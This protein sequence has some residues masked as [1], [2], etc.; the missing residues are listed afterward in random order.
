M[1]HLWKVDTGHRY[2]TR[3][4]LRPAKHARRHK[5]TGITTRYPLAGIAFLNGGD[6]LTWLVC[7]S[8][9]G[10]GVFKIDLNKP[11]KWKE[12]STFGM[13]GLPQS[14]AAPTQGD[15]PYVVLGYHGG[16]AAIWDV[17]RQ[18]VVAELTPWLAQHGK[19]AELAQRNSLCVV[20]MTPKGDRVAVGSPEDDYI[21][22]W[23][24]DGDPD[25]PDDNGCVPWRLVGQLPP[26]A[27]RRVDS[28]A[29]SLDGSLLAVGGGFK[30]GQ[31]E[32][33]DL[34]KSHCITFPAHDDAVW[35]LAFAR[36][37]KDPESTLLVS[38]SFDRTT[39]VWDLKTI[40][41]LVERSSVPWRDVPGYGGQNFSVLDLAALPRPLFHWA[42]SDTLLA[43]AVSPGSTHLATA[44]ADY[45]VSLWDFERLLEERGKSQNLRKP[46]GE[47]FHA[48]WIHPSGK[49]FAVA[50][51]NGE[52]R[53]SGE[54]GKNGGFEFNAGGDHPMRT[55]QFSRD[56]QFLAYG[57]TAGAGVHYLKAGGR[58]PI[59]TAGEKIFAVA[60]SH[61]ERKPMLALG[62]DDG[63]VL[64]AE[65]LSQKPKLIGKLHEGCV[66][67]LAFSPD[68]RWMASVGDDRILILTDLSAEDGFKH[69]EFG[70]VAGH[71]GRIK[72]IV[73]SPCG[74]FIATGGF[75]N[76]KLWKWIPGS[77]N[78]ILDATLRGHRDEIWTLAFSQS[79]RLL[80]SGSHDCTA[81]VWGRGE[82]CPTLLPAM[83]QQ[84]AFGVVERE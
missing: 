24:L 1:I 83:R 13:T 29:F 73:F 17:A 36:D 25:T 5:R 57:G 31:I 8:P 20:A 56:G 62:D 16:R 39:A 54:T 15:P 82:R 41:A 32:L 59:Q 37:P 53:V 45:V 55:V 6:K 22:I 11:E 26:P 3:I 79:G 21:R 35:A 48:A 51:A 42:L 70:T 81:R 2:L 58:D 10:I 80:V 18:H 4:P 60:F 38:G 49:Y 64:L 52:I 9:E 69:F 68:G 34:E 65:N 67:A 44:G 71:L 14:M 23:D 50:C 27:D 63:T 74:N 47:I 28:L 46:P 12:I 84:C 72:S 19:D 30:R 40:D 61:D 43:V 33:W 66:R 77:E 75:E 7:A 78:W 76:I